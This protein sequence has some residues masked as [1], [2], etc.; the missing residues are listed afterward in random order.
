MS[1][2]S[3]LV[4]LASVVADTLC[5]QVSAPVEAA[6]IH[7]RCRAPWVLEWRDAATRTSRSLEIEVVSD[8]IYGDRASVQYVVGADSV[9]RRWTVDAKDAAEAVSLRLS[10]DDYGTRL[11][12]V[13]GEQ[14]D[15]SGS[16]L[17]FDPA[18]GSVVIVRHDGKN[19]P[20]TA[21]A[22]MV[23]RFEPSHYA[24]TIEDVR[25][26]L[27]ESNDI[28]EGLWEFMDS[29]I[30]SEGTVVLSPLRLAT[31]RDGDAY[32]ILYL[33]G[34]SRTDLW[35]E[36]DVKGRLTPTPFIRDYDLLWYCADGSE[37]AGQVHAAIDEGGSILTLHLGSQP[38]TVRFRRRR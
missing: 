3:F 4:A 35:R 34:Y 36:M 31:L 30:G 19:K 28:A 22:P 10:V 26:R 7:V 23:Y 2:T 9:A 21:R 24:V 29:D 27:S 6:D 18:A 20:L 17:S 16:G 5:P 14:L 12:A 13:D 11:Y 15:L 8:N 37:L 32:V 1:A 25:K 38:M 33:G